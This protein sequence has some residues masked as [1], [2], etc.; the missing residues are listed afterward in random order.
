MSKPSAT[1]RRTSAETAS[2]ENEIGASTPLGITTIGANAKTEIVEGTTLLLG[3]KVNSGSPA[4]IAALNK[5][6]PG[7]LGGGAAA[8]DQVA[9]KHPTR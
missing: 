7:G 4:K 6:N 2:G 8:P 9:N 3:R 5:S 1:S